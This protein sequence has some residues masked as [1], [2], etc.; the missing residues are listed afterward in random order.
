MNSEISFHSLET[1]S[2]FLKFIVTSVMIFG[3]NSKMWTLKLVRPSW[4]LLFLFSEFWNRRK[5]ILKKECKSKKKEKE[6][7]LHFLSGQ[8]GGGWTA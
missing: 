5:N 1:E 8:V 4:A 2:V 7:D 6:N 3:V